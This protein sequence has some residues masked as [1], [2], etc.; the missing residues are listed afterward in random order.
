MANLNLVSA[1]LTFNAK[2]NNMR[3]FLILALMLFSNHSQASEA[4]PPEE[5]IRDS[6]AQI[7]KSIDDEFG[8]TNA[9]CI[10][11]ASVQQG[12]PDQLMI[13]SRAYFA[14][15]SMRGMWMGVSIVAAAKAVENL[16]SVK[17]LKIDL[18]NR[19]R[20]GLDNLSLCSVPVAEAKRLRQRFKSGEFKRWEEVFTASSCSKPLDQAG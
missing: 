9:A 4:P 15:E 1:V 5:N 18:A 17:E 3:N 16:A 20:H 7:V 10:P 12:Q 19:E 2:E 6:C 11:A 14:D 13:I 8:N